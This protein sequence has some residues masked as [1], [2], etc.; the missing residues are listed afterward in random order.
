MYQAKLFE[1]ESTRDGVRRYGG[2]VHYHYMSSG[3]NEESYGGAK[4]VHST[5]IEMLSNVRSQTAKCL[6]SHGE[7]GTADSVADVSNAKP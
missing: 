2:S 3:A 6:C 5:L 4:M 1:N 7:K